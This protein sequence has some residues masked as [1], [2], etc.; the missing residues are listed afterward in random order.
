[1]TEIDM[2]CR[3]KKIGLH[4]E[5]M[6]ESACPHIKHLQDAGIPHESLNLRSRLDISGIRRLRRK[7]RDEGFHV[8]HGFSNRPISNLVWSSYGLPHA[9]VVYR[10]AIGHVRRWDPDCWLKW[11]NP[12]VDRIVCVSHAVR[13]DLEKSGVRPDKIVT[14]YKGHDFSWYQDLP[15]IDLKQ[16]FGIPEESFVVGC[17]ANMR[18]VKGADVLLEA[19]F[20][21]PEHVHVLLMGEVRDPLVKKLGSKPEIKDR[22][23]F[24]GF[25]KD[26]PAILGC[27]HVAVAPSRGREGLTKSII[28]PMAQGVPAVVT[29]AG[30]LP[31]MV[32]HGVSGYVV[33]VDDARAMALAIGKLAEDTALR[34][35][36]GLKAKQ[37][38]HEVF[39]IVQTVDQT[40]D[41]YLSVCK[42]K[43]IYWQ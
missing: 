5:V 3:M 15:K 26:A 10:G 19:M 9:L 6:T 17:A 33:P 42:E 1:M 27:C 39:N 40:L 32:E 24:A 25:R 22:V 11:L 8:V 12:R 13:R 18:R 38:M 30:G 31:E 41:V 4:V 36:F 34:R 2:M 29:Q 28:E 23:H 20:E 21:L 35:K 43:K 16:E 7:I 37:R 14:V